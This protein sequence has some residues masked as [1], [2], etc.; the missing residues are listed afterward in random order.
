MSKRVS[1]PRRLVRWAGLFLILGAIILFGSDIAHST[2]AA[3][4]DFLTISDIHRFGVRP[5]DQFWVW[6]LSMVMGATL[7]A[8]A[9]RVRRERKIFHH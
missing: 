9:G 4:P 1:G 6:A 2:R 5:L 8:M 7:I 3:A